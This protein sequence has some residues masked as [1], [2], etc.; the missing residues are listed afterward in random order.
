MALLN[1]NTDKSHVGF[2]NSNLTLDARECRMKFQYGTTNV[3]IANTIIAESYMYLQVDAD[4]HLPAIMSEITDDEAE[5]D[6]IEL[7]SHKSYIIVTNGC[8]EMDKAVGNNK[9]TEK[10]CLLD[11]GSFIVMSSLTSFDGTASISSTKV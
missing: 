10:P 4:Q 2:R 9:R 8:P 3:F 6:G 11:E 5:C 7:S 1:G